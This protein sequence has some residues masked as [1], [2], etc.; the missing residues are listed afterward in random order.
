MLYF[1]SVS[2]EKMPLYSYISSNTREETI[3]VLLRHKQ[4]KCKPQKKTAMIA[5]TH[6][7]G[8]QQTIVHLA[9]VERTRTPCAEITACDKS[10]PVEYLNIK[11]NVR[12]CRKDGGGYVNRNEPKQRNATTGSRYRSPEAAAPGAAR[13]SRSAAGCSAPSN[14]RLACPP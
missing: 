6:S 4:V 11:I 7:D 1:A 14:T 13:T 5:R 3:S 9:A 2:L 12:E 10:L 8:K